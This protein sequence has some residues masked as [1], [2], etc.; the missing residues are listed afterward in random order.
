MTPTESTPPDAVAGVRSFWESLGAKVRLM[1]P[2]AHDQA[3]ALTSHLPHLVASALAGILPDELR[4]LTATGFRDTT[5]VAGGDP[6]VWT[7]IFQHNRQAVLAALARLEERLQVFRQAL[8][9]ADVAKI[10]QLLA[11]GRKV[12]DALGS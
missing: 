5:R 1:T 7:P 12:R 3:L 8:A 9:D 2:A 6:E 11:Q 10:D 4:D